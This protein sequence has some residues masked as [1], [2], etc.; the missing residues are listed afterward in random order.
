M[1]QP[2]SRRFPRRFLLNTLLLKTTNSHYMF[3]SG[4]DVRVLIIA[5][6]SSRCHNKNLAVNSGESPNHIH[7]A[8]SPL[9]S[10]NKVSSIPRQEINRGVGV[11]KCSLAPC[12]SNIRKMHHTL[13][14]A[15]LRKKEKKGT[16]QK[17]EITNA[18]KGSP[19][20]TNPF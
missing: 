14:S 5:R 7:S 17:E 13:F 19:V 4:D 9:S 6:L 12:L 18:P 3:S 1:P 10:L 2:H 15:Q 20:G 8:S 16:R 11:R